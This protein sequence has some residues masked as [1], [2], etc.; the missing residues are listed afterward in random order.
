MTDLSGLDKLIPDFWSKWDLLLQFGIANQVL[1]SFESHT[2]LFFCYI[3]DLGPKSFNHNIFYQF[4]KILSCTHFKSIYLIVNFLAE[5][6]WDDTS[7]HAPTLSIWV[8]YKSGWFGYIYVPSFH[9]LFLPQFYYLDSWQVLP[10]P[11]FSKYGLVKIGIKNHC[12]KWNWRRVLLRN[13]YL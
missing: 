1:K 6:F 13:A 2:S 11:S 7:R 4:W 5:I 10:Y 12:T 8:S 9:F 3:H